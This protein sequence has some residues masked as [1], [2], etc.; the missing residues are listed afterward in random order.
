MF[1]VSVKV[2][3]GWIWAR[4]TFVAFVTKE[5]CTNVKQIETRDFTVTCSLVEPPG[6][7][8][9]IINAVENQKKKNKKGLKF[10]MESSGS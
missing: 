5:K 8:K 3:I 10:Y 1:F 9:I 4:F 2:N 6:K 7:C